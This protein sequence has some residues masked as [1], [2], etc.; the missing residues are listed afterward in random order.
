MIWVGVIA[1]G[2]GA[3]FFYQWWMARITLGWPVAEAKLDSSAVSR[4]PRRWVVQVRYS[5]FVSG[6]HY[7]GT[8]FKC[9]RTRDEADRLVHSL[10][11]MLV[12]VRYDPKSPARSYFDP[13]RDVR[14]ETT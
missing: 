5:Y 2:L 10:S 14:I 7:G 6:N 3:W 13:Y 12:L 4:G 8:W 11:D 9:F 1:G